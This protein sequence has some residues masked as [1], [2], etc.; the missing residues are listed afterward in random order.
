MQ[1]EKVIRLK[2]GEEVLA[3]LR[4]H[5]ITRFWRG[6]LVLLLVIAPFFFMIPLFGFGIIGSAIF[7]LS[8][9]S[10][11]Y[12]GGR[13]FFLWYWNA[14]IVTDMRVIDIDQRG[15][16]SRTVSEADLE[17]IQDVSFSVRGIRGAV[18]GFGSLLIQTAGATANLELSAA[19]DPKEAHHLITEAMAARRGAQVMTDDEGKVVGKRS[20]K[21]SQLLD[22]AAE[23]DGPEARAFLT[24]IQQAVNKK[25][26][27]EEP[28]LSWLG[29]T[30]EGEEPEDKAHLRH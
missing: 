23:L 30:E 20:A 3:I 13:E 10:G 11:M 19:A 21:V 27:R 8:I 12:L 7:A 9:F 5:W 1:V 25:E 6:V 22:A 14:F 29:K 17:R 2:D 24:A 15:W 16:F 26:T 28:D 4:N 18:F